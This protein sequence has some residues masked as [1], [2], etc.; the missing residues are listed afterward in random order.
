MPVSSPSST[1]RALFVIATAALLL[2][3]IVSITGG[4]VLEAW[5]VRLSVR[6][7]IRPVVLAA[8]AIAWLLFRHRA[9]AGELA[10][11][12][13]PFLERRAALIAVVVAAAAAAEGI[14]WNTYAAS[15]SDAAGYVSQADLMAHGTLTFAA[16]LSARMS[17]PGATQVFAPFAYRPGPTPGEL[18]PTY[19][20]GLPLVMAVAQ[21]AGGDFA[22]YVVIPL[23]G[24]LAV[25]SAFV[26]GRR[27]H[28]AAA[29]LVAAVLLA[30][31]PIFLFEVAQPM[32][33]VAAATWWIAA[34]ALASR[35]TL[36][37]AV[38]AGLAAGLA[39][40]TRPVALPLLL[41]VAIVLTAMVPP[42]TEP[43][44]RGRR[45]R[46]LVA[47]GAGF[48][49]FPA[50]LAMLQQRLYGTPFGSGHG[51]IGEMFGLS[52]VAENVSRYTARFT[53]GETPM[54]VLAAVAL[55][56]LIVR[57]AP[58]TWRELRTPVVVAVASL[59]VM[60]VCYLPYGIFGEWWYFRF[61]LPALPPIFVAA[62]A[63]TCQAAMRM[64][65][66]LRGVALLL[67]LAAVASLNIVEAKRQEAFLVRRSEARYQITGAYLAGMLPVNA[68]VVSVQ[69]SASAHHYARRPIARW[70]AMPMG[71]DRA[72]ADLAAAGQHPYLVLEEWEEAELPKR[73]PES[74]L[75]RLDWRPIADIGDHVHVRVYDTIN[76]RAVLA[77]VDPR[78]DRIHAP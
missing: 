30:T 70:D 42:G 15:G 63:L 17:W 7:E 13:W 59:A 65:P 73:F 34:L 46:A 49:P 50:A 12:T 32:S 77:P 78:V 20:P 53:T 55:L 36:S 57:R 74:A 75:A 6:N 25:F 31:S 18:V 72:V 37:G 10:R 54:L 71:L 64:P 26:L 24:A 41:P 56:V 68:V 45:F 43:A 4:F 19:P 29:G 9:A 66:A 1:S 52:N 48:A 40:L 11:Q 44:L 35:G 33:D 22:P 60:L 58:G 3:V 62:G 28:S 51:S 47:L 69:H 67:A 76:R 16:P 39:F 2:V 38:A 21:L 61:F 5:S 14:F 8:A 27:L 23:L